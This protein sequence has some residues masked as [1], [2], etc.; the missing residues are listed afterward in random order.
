MHSEVVMTKTELWSERVARLDAS[1]LS[2]PAFARQEGVNTNTLQWWRHTLR[3][4][5]EEPLTRTEGP[6]FVAVE[7]ASAEPVAG[8]GFVV[9]LGGSG[10]RIEV[11]ADFDAT[12]LR[13][14]VGALC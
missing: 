9:Q 10:H 7:V 6:R 2:V 12:A 3:R 4:K 5:R 13:R 1:G 8:G 11:P 14:L